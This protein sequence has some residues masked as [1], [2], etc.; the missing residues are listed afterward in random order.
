MTTITPSQWAGEFSALNLQG[1]LTYQFTSSVATDFLTLTT[2][3][4]TIDFGTTPLDVLIP[5]GGTYRLHVHT[6]ASCG[7]Q[8]TNRTTTAQALLFCPR[9]AGLTAS[10]LTPTGA[11]LRWNNLANATSWQV[12]YGLAGFALGTGTQQ[13]AADTTLALGGLQ[14]ATTYQAYVRAF[15]GPTDTSAW[16]LPVSFT[17]QCLPFAAPFSQNFD[18]TP[19]LGLPTCWTGIAIGSNSSVR[20][21]VINTAT[22]SSL[23]N[24]L[25][26]YNSSTAGAAQHLM[27]VSPSL[28]DLGAGT[29]QLR[30]RA[31]RGFSAE[32]LVIGTM[33]DPTNPA[34]FTALTTITTLTTTHQEFQVSFADYTGTDTH[35]AFR[36]ANTGADR[37]LYIDDIFWEAAPACPRPTALTTSNATSGSITLGWTPGGSETQWEVIYGPTGFALGA[38]TSVVADSNPFVLTGLSPATSYQYYLRAICSEGGTSVYA[39]PA[40][41]T[42]PCQPPIISTFPYTENFD[43]ET[44]PA[45]PCGWT[46]ENLNNDGFTWATFSSTNAQSASNVLSIRYNSSQAMDDWA[47]T[48]ELILTA[49]TSYVVRFGYRAQSASFPERLKVHIGNS[50]TVTAM[51]TLLGDLG[52]F[53]NVTYQLAEFIFTPT[54]TGSY[55]VGLHGYSIADQ[56]RILVDNFEVDIAPDCPTPSSLTASNLATTSATL[57]WNGIATAQS[58]VLEFREGTEGLWTTVPTS[59]TSAALTDLAPATL[60]EA[61][62]QSICSASSESNFSATITFRTRPTNDLCAD[63]ITVTCGTSGLAGTNFGATGTGAPTGFCGTTPGSFGV[64]YTFVGTGDSVT[65]NT[66]G[67]PNNFD[68]KLNVY[69]GSCGA[70]VCMGG[71]DDTGGLQSQVRFVSV[72]GTTYF[73]YV[74]GIGTARGDFVLNLVCT[75]PSTCL[76]PSGLTATNVTFNGATL[77]WTAS[78]TAE[79]YVV[80]F[81]PGTSGAWTMDTTTATTRTLSGLASGTLHQ[82]RVRALCADTTESIFS[83]TVSFTTPFPVPANDLCANALTVT[84]GTTGLAGTNQGATGT[85]GPTTSCGTTPGSFGVW[86]TFVGT[87]D[88]VNVNTFG[89][90]LNTK[91]NVYRGSC[92]G[93]VCVGGNDDAG[94]TLQSQVRFLSVSDTTYFIYVTGFGTARGNF[95]LNLSCTVPPA[96]LPPTA[97][98]SSG[99]TATTATLNWTASASATSYVVEFREG[100]SGDWTMDTTSATTLTLTGL[101]GNT[102]HQARVRALCPEA[103]ESTFSNTVSFTT[104]FPVPPNDLCADAIT[105]T[106]GTTG[107]AGTNQNATGTGGPT[108]NCGTV[109]G[110]S[111]VWYTFVGT[112]DSVNVNTCAPTGFDTKLN[113]YS[114]SCGSFTCVG[115]NDDF[116]GVRSQVVFLSEVGTTYYIYVTGFGS[117][118]GNF[119]LNLSCTA[120]PACL[121]PTGLAATNVTASGATLNWTASA[122]ATSYVVEFREGTSGDWTMDTTSATTLTLSGLAPSTQHQARVR[123]LCADTLESTFSNTVSFTTAP[124]C[125]APTGLAATNVTA[126]GATLNWTASAS[127]TSY[128]VEFRVGTS[129]A[130]T[131]DTTTAT[132]LTLSG[133]ASGT[134]YQARVRALC[135]EALESTFSNTVSFT[136]LFPV[137]PNDL[138]AD[139]ITV[140]CGTTGLAGTNQGATGTGGPTTNCGTVP[141]SSGVWY[142]FVGTGDEVTVNTCAPSGLDTKLNV[143]RGACDS[144]VCVGGNDDFCSLRSQVVFVSEVGTTY[145]FYV[146]GF[147]AARGNF[148]LNVTCVPVPANDLC[149]NA[150]TVTCGTTGLAGTNIGATGTGAP[151]AN[152]G[153][154]PGNFGVWYTFAGTGDTVTVNTFGSPNNFD[155]KLNVYSG[156]CGA[157]VCV[158]GNDDAGGTRQSQVRFVSVSGTTYY[159]YVTGF[160]SITRGNFVLNVS[161]VAPP[162]A[163]FST[164]NCDQLTVNPDSTYT[165]NWANGAGGIAGQA[166]L[167]TGFTVVYPPDSRLS[168]DG[169]APDSTVPGYQ[170]NLLVVDPSV[171]TLSL[172][173]PKGTALGAANTQLNMLAVKAATAGVTL[174]ARAELLVLPDPGTASG[175]EAGLW[176]G[177]DQDNYV[178]LVAKARGNGYEIL[179]LHEANGTTVDSTQVADSVALGDNVLLSFQLNP[180]TA[181]VQAFYEL[182]RD[183][184][185]VA[186]GSTLTVADTLFTGAALNDGFGT[187]VGI[188]GTQ[189]DADEPLTFTFG[190]FTL[191]SSDN[192]LPITLLDFTARR[193]ERGVQLDWQTLSE[194]DNDYFILERSKDGRAF[195]SIVRLEGA[196]S[197]QGLRSYTYLDEQPLSGRSYYR[198]RQTD[199]DGTS[200]LSLVRMV[201]RNQEELRA[202]RAFPNPNSGARIQ[203]E[204]E[205]LNADE[206]LTLGLY[207]A[208][209]RPVYRMEARSDAGGQYVGTLQPARKLSGGMYWLQVSTPYS[210]WQQKIIVR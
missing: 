193:T 97:L 60:Y 158:G 207:D 200:S 21:R 197:H 150:T 56:S 15:C 180:V 179:L 159:F 136:T 5:A 156:S 25:E 119:V 105:V 82:A 45:L 4:D 148:V 14:P 28:T 165:P 37:F 178:K 103:L 78:A 111:G 46:F 48:P 190:E 75:P 181:S 166:G 101:A 6:N 63:A 20:V 164:L 41:F 124:A 35:I 144:L 30:F 67:S 169:P 9:P 126:S 36:H 98:A 90:T 149:T 189:A 184:N 195:A 110:S 91:L 208:L 71:N 162:C 209:G 7:T 170:P 13:G 116:C 100:T 120:P 210:Q 133:L 27:F 79:S 114:G 89:S 145:Y 81:R 80:E 66:F 185:P 88:S 96:C 22:P 8:S 196:G 70:L 16:S 160:S 206:A 85:G 198:L 50:A 69:S 115:G 95:V 86:Y 174:E 62:V 123:A 182:N 153:T 113:V 176:F 84:C 43:A 57:S 139:A 202:F 175:Q 44:A 137:P 92:A 146:T 49:G 135:A 68:S 11:Q 140:T 167:G 102:L 154:T 199:F 33:S 143:Y 12:E 108:A 117:A 47:Y 157:L 93:L 141:G 17:T 172:T 121:A 42:T 204:L 53:N 192:P 203:V 151:T 125:P 58:Y 194:T 134:Q 59:D 130:W 74:T 65:V 61:R 55:F 131:M 183:G 39:G 128:V 147:G 127:A 87:G 32:N 173:T 34:T 99:L 187:L 24:H 122:S 40:S 19:N 1:G 138:C 18:S 10:S 188:M 155:T 38:G 129:G 171:G 64:W 94:G 3:T 109:P 168:E 107:L 112:G 186:V 72:S 201:D 142:R 77:N 177:I 106:C 163:P 23:P 73:I 83:N 51:T 132:T 118:T 152:C 2:A 104:P 31:R 26:M 161:C 54:T 205:G 191:L 52:S 29:N 76:A